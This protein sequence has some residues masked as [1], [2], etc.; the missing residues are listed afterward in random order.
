M[1]EPITFEFG[2][3]DGLEGWIGGFADYPFGAEG[4]FELNWDWQ[5][6]PDVLEGN[7]IYITGNNRSDDL[8]MFVKRRVEGLKPNAQ[9]QLVFEVRFATS[10][11]KLPVRPVL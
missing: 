2:F 5:P 9:Y 3:S 1:P 8:F 10:V 4:T 6:L 11:R 7:G